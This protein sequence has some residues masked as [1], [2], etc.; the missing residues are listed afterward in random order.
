MREIKTCKKCGSEK[1]IDEF[2]AKTKTRKQSYCKVCFNTYCKDRWKT[3]RLDALK[4]FGGK[5]SMCGYSKC[6]DALEFHHVDPTTKKYDWNRLKMVSQSA[7][8]KE[9][10]KCVLVCANCHREIHSQTPVAG[11]EPA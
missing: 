6:L 9:L 3:R 11:V 7:L 8:E 5:C 4:K 10:K 1:P 2:Y